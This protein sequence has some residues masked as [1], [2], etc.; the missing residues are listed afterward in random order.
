[1]KSNLDWTNEIEKKYKLEGPEERD[2]IRD[3]ALKS[4]LEFEWIGLQRDWVPD[5]ENSAMKEA[6]VLLRIRH[7]TFYKGKGSKWELTLKE[8]SVVDGVHINKELAANSDTAADLRA[9]EEDL[10]ERLGKKINLSRMA[11]LDYEYAFQAGLSKHRMFIEKNRALYRDK[12]RKVILTFDELPE[13]LGFFVEL[14]VESQEMFDEWEAKLGLDKL[15]VIT[16]DYGELVKKEGK[17]VL[18]FTK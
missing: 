4:G 13:P 6:G 12:K 15:P 3:L 11:N 9:L 16:D 1:M 14:E 8:K 5:Y 2:K 10:Q 7:N 18:V 17:R